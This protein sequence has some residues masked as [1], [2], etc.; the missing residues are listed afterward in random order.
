MRKQ[1]LTVADVAIYLKNDQWWS[2]D[3]LTTGELVG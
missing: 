3:L 1:M 2:R